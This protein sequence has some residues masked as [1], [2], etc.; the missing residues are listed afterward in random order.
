MP[1]ARA[2]PVTA[3]F[4]SFMIA[5]LVRTLGVV[6][7]GLGTFEATSVIALTLTGISSAAALA[8]TLLFR[9]LSFWL[10]M[11]PGFV[12]SRAALRRLP[13]RAQRDAWWTQDPDTTFRELGSGP[14]GL[15]ETEARQRLLRGGRNTLAEEGRLTGAAILLR[16]VT[17]PLLLLLFFAV[18]VSMVNGE[19]LDSMIV[20]TIIVTSV[21]IT[22]SRELSA[23]AAVTALRERLHA[24]TQVVREGRTRDI[25]IDEIVPGDVIVLSAGHL[26][27]ADAVVVSA[28]HCYAS[29]ALLTGESFPVEK[30]PGVSVLEAPLHRRS[31]CVHLGTAIQSGSAT[32][33]A[34]RTASSTEMGRL[35]G[36]LVMNKP[37][38]EFERGLRHF[39][40]LLITTMLI[41]VIVVFVTH[42]VFHGRPASDTLLF[43]VALAVG[44]S[45]ELLPAILTANLARDAKSMVSRGVLVRRLN[46]IENLGS[47]DVLCTD[48]TGTL[49]EGVV[50]L[51]S[52]VNPDGEPDDHVLA[53]AAWNARLTAGIAGPL[54]AAIVSAAPAAAL[55]AKLADIPFDPTRR[56]V[57]IVVR[58]DDSALLIG[59]GAIEAVLQ[60]CVTRRGVPLTDADRASLRARYVQWGTR[61]IRVLGV[62]T[63]TIAHKA[64]YGPADEEGL[65]FTGFLTFV[66]RVKADA[67]EA[68][69]SLRQLGVSVVLITGDNGLVAAHVAQA[70]GLSTGVVRGQDLQALPEVALA[71]LAERTQVFAELDP[72][73]KERIVAA[74]RRNGHVVGFLGDGINDVAAMHAADTSLAVDAAIDV[75]HQAADFVLLE[76]GL[77]VIRRGVED[78]RRTFANTLKYILITMSANLGNMMSMAAASLVLPF[79]PM[80]AGQVLLNN[81][82]SD[83]P[84]VGLAGDRVDRE[85]I[86][87][88]RRWNITA[89]GRYMVRFGL[90]SSAFDALT[91]AL[92]LL[93]FH[94]APATFRTAWFVESLLTE[95]AVALV[96]RT[97]R[98]FHQSRPGTVLL[99]STLGVACLALIIP[100]VPG[101]RFIGFVPIPAPIMLVVV[102]I[103]GAYVIAAEMAKRRL[104]TI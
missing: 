47:M 99:A 85:L 6:P 91:F 45:P 78:G 95:L 64:T 71:Q 75:A 13:Q 83:I 90:L 43:S 52:A 53:M 51:D 28:S 5:S 34:V 66:D 67:T 96:V 49:T 1:W 17:S 79:L 69:A 25:A 81:F 89:I 7:G 59:K 41:M 102:T 74:L 3:V 76:R 94:A 19:W 2:G 77:D 54:D 35:A 82:L 98:P 22:M 29:E 58:T 10:P 38:T 101:T 32:A 36:R 9:G 21:A 48:K 16:Q 72:E 42:V 87:R 11:G 37:E 88:P 62:A 93:V 26:V 86:E 24:I 46:A 39:G 63:R 84:A 20:L 31:N 73:Q 55:P 14:T 18:A 27:A 40:Y 23:Q 33:V 104:T 56:R 100:Y 50:R 80:S 60:V 44:L 68:I 61:G 12:A 70:V 15:T 92:L 97:R 103:T 30:R 57:S 8:A 65:D 4:A